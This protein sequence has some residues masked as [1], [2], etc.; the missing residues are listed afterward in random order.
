MATE[1][2]AQLTESARAKVETV[3]KREFDGVMAVV[4]RADIPY[5]A[6]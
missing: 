2:I 3:T 1:G 5:L 6:R 4:V